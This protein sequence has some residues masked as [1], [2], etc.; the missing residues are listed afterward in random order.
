[1]S[2]WK[3]T[4]QEAGLDSLSAELRK[5]PAPEPP[6]DLVG[7]ILRSR[8]AGVR[9]ALPRGQRRC[10]ARWVVGAIAAAA[11]VAVVT[12]T[13]DGGRPPADTDNPYQDV[14]AA[15][16]FWPPDAVAQEAGPPRPPRYEPVR[17]L[18]VARAHGGTWTYRT[19]TMFDDVTKCRG[20]LTI[21]VADAQWEG[22]SV[23]LVSQQ[24]ISVRDG[25]PDIRSSL[26]TTY[27]ELASV[28]PIYAAMGGAQ[29]R[30]V[31]RFTRDSVR[32]ALDIGG[33]HPRSWRARASIPGAPD[34]PLV[35]RWARVDL[36]LLLQ[37]LPLDR[38]WRGSVYSVRLVGPDPSKTGFAPIDLR[39]VGSGRI[40]VPA[41]RFDCWKLELR[42]GQESVLTLWVSKDRGWLV[43]TEPRASDWRTESV[44]VSATPPAP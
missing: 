8:A 32:E 39:F 44:L 40:E 23:W 2:I 38:G 12:S 7:R 18:R 6:P 27:F 33:A 1:M 9:V 17:G 43:K 36:T 25:S 15:L 31:R 21:T 16:S 37:V 42:D 35:L 30:L 28:R 20:R 26:D 24:E 5:L 19:C 10:A 3:W 34:A 22:Q 4:E 13:R 41:G 29:F 11:V 14:P